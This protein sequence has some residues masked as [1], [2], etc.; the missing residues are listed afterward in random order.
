MRE[1]RRPSGFEVELRDAKLAMELAVDRAPDE[2]FKYE[3]KGILSRVEDLLEMAT[4]ENK[5]V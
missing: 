3:A 1:R 4:K 5:H 2:H